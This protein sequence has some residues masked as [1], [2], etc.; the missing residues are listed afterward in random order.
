M[1]IQDIFSNFSLE[2]NQ[3]NPNTVNQSSS[4]LDSLSSMI[5]GGLAGGAAAGGIM[6]L[7]MGSK[8]HKKWL[9]KWLNMAEQQ[10]LVV[11]PIR[12]L[13]IGKT[14]RHWGKLKRLTIMISS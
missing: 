9:K 11:W 7:L 12:L 3:Q 8:S 14:I 1:N 10:F 13:I 4:P 5:P 2:S 6:A